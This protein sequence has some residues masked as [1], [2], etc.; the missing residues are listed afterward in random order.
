MRFFLFF[1]LTLLFVQK[2]FCFPSSAFSRITIFSMKKR[3]DFLTKP[4]I[5]RRLEISVPDL[6]DESGELIFHFER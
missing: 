4:L 1:F 5:G 3:D 2:S 6:V